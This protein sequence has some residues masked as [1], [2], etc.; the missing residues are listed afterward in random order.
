MKES[1]NSKQLRALTF[2]AFLVPVM[3]L[4]P[5]YTARTAGSGAYLAPFIAL[6]L[7]LLYICFLTA[8]LRERNDNEGLGEMLLKSGGSVFGRAV[9]AITWL[10]ALFFSRL[11]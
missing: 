2:L 1:Y 11:L 6:P 9:L 8:L 10:F 5:K 3:R 4:V 7:I